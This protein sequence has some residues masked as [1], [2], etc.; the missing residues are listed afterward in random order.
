MFREAL[1]LPVLTPAIS[2]LPETPEAVR[3]QMKKGP[4]VPTSSK[5]HAAMDK[6]KKLSQ[7]GTSMEKARNFL[8][9]IA[10]KS[11]FIC[12]SNRYFRGY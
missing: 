5:V 4:D 8:I 11:F 7:E 1:D 3:Q 2:P 12:F 10:M 6:L 9:L